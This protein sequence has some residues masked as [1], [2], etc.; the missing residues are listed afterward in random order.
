M[1]LTLLSYRLAPENPFPTALLE[2]FAVTQFV[3]ENT[4]ILKMNPE[5]LTLMGTYILM[6]LFNFRHFWKESKST[7]GF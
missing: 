2:C 7:K 3:L 6:G 4:Q 1:L 5:N